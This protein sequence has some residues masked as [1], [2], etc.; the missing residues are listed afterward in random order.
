MKKE[1]LEDLYK[2]TP[3]QEGMLFHSLQAPGDCLYLEQF[4]QEVERISHE[5]LENTWAE[6]LAQHAILRTGFFYQN[7]D[8]P[9]QVVFRKLSVPIDY[10]DW[11]DRTPEEAAQLLDDYQN[12]DRE[13]A[14]DLDKAPLMRLALLQLPNDR[15]YFLWSYHHILL[16]G[17]SAFNVIEHFFQLLTCH[18]QQRPPVVHKA[19]PF[20]DY[21]RWLDSRDQTLETRHWS[22]YLQGFQAPTPLSIAASHDTSIKH[23]TSQRHLGLAVADRLRQFARQQHLT[24]NTLLQ[25]SWGYLLA[26][27][28]GE[29][30]VLFGATCA[31][32]PTGLPLADK[33]IGL[34]INTLPCR[35]RLGDGKTITRD[36]LKG[37]QTEQIDNREFEHSSLSVIQGQSQVPAGVSLFDSILAVESFP[38]I[39]NLSLPDVNVSQRTNYP[40]TLVVEPEGAITLKAMYNTGRFAEDA[41]IR[42][43]DQWAWLLEQLP[44]KAELPLSTLTLMPASSPAVMPAKRTETL[45]GLIR[46]QALQH[47]DR[48]ALASAKGQLTYAQL[49]DRANAL[50]SHL[51]VKGIGANSKIGIMFN[52]HPDMLIALLAV[53]KLGGT[54][55]PLDPQWPIARLETIK[56]NLSLDTLI[57][58]SQ[59]HGQLQPRTDLDLLSLEKSG[60]VISQSSADQL[61]YV[62]HTSGSTGTPKAAAVY[63][64]SFMNLVLWWNQEFGL[65][66][67][68]SNLLVTKLS[69]DLTQKNIWAPLIAGG[70]IHVA[71][72]DH[73]DPASLLEQLRNSQATWLNCTPSMAYALLESGADW[74]VLTGLRWLHLGG[75]PIDLARLASWF[76][77]P[78]NQCTLVNNYGPTEATD[79]TTVYRVTEQDF[80]KNTHLLPVGSAIPGITL[81]VLD[82]FG[83]ALPVGVR[84]E[85]SVAG[86]AVGHGYLGDQARTDEKFLWD[87]RAQGGRR[88]LT[89]DMGWL[90]EEGV[91]MVSGRK[92]HQIKLRGFRIELAEIEAHLLALPQVKAAAVIKAEEALW[93]YIELQDA[94]NATTP[95]QWDSLLRQ[96]LPYYLLPSAYRVLGK[97][98]LNNHG[99]LDRHQLPVLTAD[100]R[101]GNRE[102]QAPRTETEKRLAKLWQELLGQKEE[103]G[104]HNNFFACGGHSLLLTRLFGRIPKFFEVQ[105]PLGT[106]FANPTIAQQANLIDKAGKRLSPPKPAVDIPAN[107]PL[108][109][110]QRRMWFL[111]AYQPDNPAYHIYNQHP[112]Q[113]RYT[114]TELEQALDKLVARHAILRTRF[115]A[116][117]GVPSQVVDAKGKIPVRVED[118]SSLD[119][120]TLEEQLSLIAAQSVLARYDLA[121]GP[122]TRVILVYTAEQA[123]LFL[124]QHHIVTDGWS[125]QLLLEELDNYLRAP[126]GELP[127]LPISYLD[128]SLWQETQ[129]RD[130][131]F[132][133]D[134]DYWQTQLQ[135]SRHEIALPFDR[136]R[137]AQVDH[138]GGL[139]LQHLNPA[140]SRQLNTLAQQHKTTVFNVLMAAFGVLLYRLSDQDDFNLGTP[141]AGRN[142]AEL[143]N[144]QGLFVNTLVI[145]QQPKATHS[146]LE[147]LQQVITTT[148]TA[149]DHQLLPFEYLVESLDKQRDSRLN[150][151]FQ[152]MFS[153]R[154]TYEDMSL[155]TQHGD[156]GWVARFDLQLTGS[157]TGSGLL[158]QWEYA[159]ALFNHSS[160]TAITGYFETLLESIVSKPQQTLKQLDILPA[161][162]A[163]DVFKSL[164]PAARRY[165]K[166]EGLGLRFSR[167][168]QQ[169]PDALAVICGDDVCTYAELEQRSNQLAQWLLQQGIKTEEPVGVA[170]PRGIL[171]S[172]CLLALVKLGAAYVPLD[173]EYPQERLEHMAL[174][175]QIRHL[176]GNRINSDTFM[177]LGCQVHLVDTN[178]FA[179]AINQCN[180]Q[181]PAQDTIV[182]QRCPAYISYTSGTTGQPKGVSVSQQAVMRLVD[183]NIFCPLNSE[184]RM[185]QIAPVAF[186]ASTFEIWGALLNGGTLVCYP[187]KL[188]DI[189]VMEKII[190]RYDVNTTFITAG[191]FR[192]WMAQLKEPTG[193]KYLMTGGDVVSP[194]AVQKLYAIDADV[195]CING[196]GPTENTTFSLY[197]VIPR[198]FDPRQSIPIGYCLAN[199]SALVLDDYQRICPP[200]VAGEL[201]VGGDGV[202]LGYFNAA[203]LT[204]QK[205]V[206]LQLPSGEHQRFYKTGDRVRQDKNGCVIF[207]GRNDHQ[208]KIRGFRIEPGEIQNALC[209]HPQVADVFVAVQENVAG[210]QLVAYLVAA[211]NTQP[212]VADI[213][214]YAQRKLPAYMQPAHYVL[215]ESL[216]LTTNGKVDLRRLPIPQTG[217][218]ENKLVIPET[219]Q[220]KDLFAIWCEVLG[221]NEFGIDDDFFAL[222]GHSLLAVRT[223][224]LIRERLDYELSLYAFFSAPTLREQAQGL[225]H[226]QQSKSLQGEEEAGCL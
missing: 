222:G 211:G 185:L 135:D 184:T 82:Q 47:P 150:P 160:L 92:D 220:E 42:L 119:E 110:A 137:P 115:P 16:D 120:K 151:L 216:P 60:Q 121:S 52:P 154:D 43:L 91:L 124:A 125:T 84:G 218:S 180:N 32:R 50:A 181:L 155:L 169:Q 27:Y 74:N 168:A 173:P 35:I 8:K 46:Q 38:V 156:D 56:S 196:Y 146:F 68:D 67:S 179:A 34:F 134:L 21:V 61:L 108:S 109:F 219:Q 161:Q 93:A 3:I 88:Y 126:Q 11:S 18:Y 223:T 73:F 62:I 45:D 205:F 17:W 202:A 226:Y 96:Q 51:Q 116:V 130:G 86:I 4:G 79:I 70:C 90:T 189:P 139:L 138:Q 94:T 22:N 23:I 141:I 206:V 44:E 170:L 127:S 81:D 117:E 167:I 114:Q 175:S 77:H 182:T 31:G 166:E 132:Q 98:P 13:R 177:Q 162:K 209:D 193:L 199:A 190:H 24:L 118:L 55:V 194:Q 212:E 63:H 163:F 221:I 208:V 174:N 123:F 89:G 195:M 128:Y 65:S 105:I 204:A 201:Y 85:V 158:L 152:V 15:S 153:W 102:F 111:S 26:T 40:L 39:E 103:I 36:W 140:L 54:Y 41:I 113:R 224:A 101:P 5:L 107:P 83:N 176:L 200:G 104:V 133:D 183:N 213:R 188:I 122:L 72:N 164:Q 49:E 75:E 215:M 12:R 157:S 76:T 2:L 30:D 225:V 37:L 99:K 210:K 20:K 159:K 187:D 66:T 48:L 7:L 145:R 19:P 28:A 207:L 112:L 59:L 57:T 95:D 143:E 214:R 149:I 71:T 171:Q 178:E 69:F 58:H 142:F 144:L 6:L 148:R 1:N 87:P 106:L 53:V 14:F 136:P 186:D 29:R 131:H 25:A 64:H 10:I 217:L 147:H 192:E 197:Y 9:V 203:E 165:A 191:L 33:M 78:L 80:A 129:L 100:D 198:D 172:T 97:L